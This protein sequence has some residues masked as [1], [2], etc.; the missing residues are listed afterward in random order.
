MARGPRPAREPIVTRALGIRILFV[1]ALIVA[2]TFVVFSFEL[3]RTGDLDAARTAA[4][5]MV[6]VGEMGY[7]LQVRRFT[8]SGLAFPGF[9]E[10]RVVVAVIGLLVVVQVAFTYVPFMNVVFQTAPIDGAAWVLIVVL[11]TAQ[12]FAVEIEKAL[13][14]AR[15]LQTF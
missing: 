4:V 13:W 3:E 11:A 10:S 6:V 2:A 5:A 9:R 15:G 8:E 7:L 1:G 12:F 14:R